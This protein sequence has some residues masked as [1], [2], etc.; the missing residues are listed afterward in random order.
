MTQNV[1]SHF[2]VISPSYSLDK[3][4]GFQSVCLPTAWATGAYKSAFTAPSHTVSNICSVAL[5]LSPA[6][7]NAAFA[8]TPQPLKQHVILLR[9]PKL[10]TFCSFSNTALPP[11][12]HPLTLR[13]RGISSTNCIQT[14]SPIG[15]ER[16]EWSWKLLPW[17][18]EITIF[19]WNN[20]SVL[21]L[22]T[23]TM[24]SEDLS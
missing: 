12:L 6:Y 17:G 10:S 19:Q 22:L 9:H 8:P 11:S 4:T 23:L 2:R 24:S 18:S 3:Q 1:F 21:A 20:L 13:T 14:V 15:T 16:S 5:T 7:T